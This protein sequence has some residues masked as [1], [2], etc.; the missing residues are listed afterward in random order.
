[1]FFNDLFSLNGQGIPQENKYFTANVE[2][3]VSLLVWKYTHCLYLTK[4]LLE[5][6]K[7]NSENYWLSY[8]IRLIRLVFTVIFHCSYL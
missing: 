8:S 4:A 1:M 3:A 7:M 5:E 6:K 2:L